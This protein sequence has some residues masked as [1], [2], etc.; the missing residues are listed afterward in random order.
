MQ[1]F[2]YFRCNYIEIIY[3]GVFGFDGGRIGHISEPGT[4]SARK[5]MAI[6]IFKWQ[7]KLRFSSLIATSPVAQLAGGGNEVTMQ[8]TLTLLLSRAVGKLQ[9]WQSGGFV[10]RTSSCEI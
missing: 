2:A 3:G 4:S 6:V 10:G 8:A 5:T 7:Q 9:S 1:D